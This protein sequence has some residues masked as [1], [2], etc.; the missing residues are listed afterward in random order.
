MVDLA[1]ESTVKEERRPYVQERHSNLQIQHLSDLLDFANESLFNGEMVNRNT[2][3]AA[4]RLQLI[5]AA[6]P[7]T[8]IRYSVPA[9]IPTPEKLD[10]KLGAAPDAIDVGNYETMTGATVNE[11]VTFEVADAIKVLAEATTRQGQALREAGRAR[12]HLI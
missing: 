7:Y 11:R 2:R 8:R 6:L 12:R 9:P 5:D 10:L 3:S 1:G 4:S